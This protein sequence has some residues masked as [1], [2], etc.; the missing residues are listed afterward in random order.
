MTQPA[1]TVLHD[2]TGAMLI[3]RTGPR[4]TRV[5]VRT[6]EELTQA[7]RTVM[8]LLAPQE[9]GPCF[10]ALGQGYERHLEAAMDRIAASYD[11]SDTEAL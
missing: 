8:H 10:V 3:V 7:K 11:P 4:Q 9:R 1:W 2:H 5:L 6:L